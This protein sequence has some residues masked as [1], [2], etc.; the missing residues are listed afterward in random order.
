MDRVDGTGVAASGGLGLGLSGSAK[1]SV[2]VISDSDVLK[3]TS[4]FFGTA[5][6]AGYSAPP[7][8]NADVGLTSV[9]MGA[10]IGLSAVL[11]C[12]I[13]F[14]AIFLRRKRSESESAKA[15][16]EAETE[17]DSTV[18]ATYVDDDAEELEAVNPLLSD[19]NIDEMSG[20]DADESV[21]FLYW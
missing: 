19:E 4:S 17:A 13:L 21:S 2:S 7:Q 8:E 5:S 1:L 11:V 9:L 12:G 18:V 15:E 20:D 3:A 14:W 6:L 10:G 16:A